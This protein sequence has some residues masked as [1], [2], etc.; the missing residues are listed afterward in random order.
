MIV[1]PCFNPMLVFF[2]LDS[3]S[4]CEAVGLIQERKSNVNPVPALVG[5]A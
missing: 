2:Y 1:R 5:Q 4:V 3:M